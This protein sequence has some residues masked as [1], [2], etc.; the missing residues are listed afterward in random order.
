MKIC[1]V[2]FTGNQSDR[3]NEMG[4]SYVNTKDLD[5][6]GDVNTEN[7]I[8]SNFNNA[9]AIPDTERLNSD[10]YYSVADSKID[11]DFAT[12]DVDTADWNN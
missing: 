3:R 4:L 11:S 1:A 2:C 9:D 7:S 5:N 6:G 8:A 10:P 12:M